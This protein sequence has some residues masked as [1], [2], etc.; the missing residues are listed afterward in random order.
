MV[1][2]ALRVRAM[3]Y[4]RALCASVECSRAVGC[5]RAHARASEC[6]G[7]RTCHRHHHLLGRL[8]PAPPRPSQ[9]R[10]RAPQATD[11][12]PSRAPQQPSHGS[13]CRPV[14]VD[15]PNPTRFSSA[16][17]CRFE[18]ESALEKRGSSTHRATP[19]NQVKQ[20]GI[21]PRT[22]RVGVG[23]RAARQAEDGGGGPATKNGLPLL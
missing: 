2:L 3:L 6:A 18:R 20:A 12:P 10:L 1:A 22:S 7:E 19:H 15:T 11:D 14:A 9:A 21:E 8:L 13:A 5:K 17:S 16:L 23:S 4:L